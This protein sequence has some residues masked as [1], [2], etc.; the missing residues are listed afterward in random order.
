MSGRQIVDKVMYHE[1]E[2]DTEEELKEAVGKEARVCG[3]EVRRY[4]EKND[5]PRIEI[6]NFH[7]DGVRWVGRVGTP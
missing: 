2:F 3:D 6:Y 5:P 1:W 7:Q 4:T